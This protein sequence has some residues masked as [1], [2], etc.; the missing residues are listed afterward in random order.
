LLCSK[1][2][3]FL[4]FYSEFELISNPLGVAIAAKFNNY[5]FAD[6]KEQVIELLQR[7]CTVNVKNM[8]IIQ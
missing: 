4:L 3:N 1:S 6:Y 8:G 2:F 5:R 7:V